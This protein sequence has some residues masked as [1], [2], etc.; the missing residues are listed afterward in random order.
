MTKWILPRIVHTIHEEQLAEHGGASGVRDE[1]LLDSAL[2]RPKN[3]AAYG[4]PP[5]N[6]FELAASYAY[7]IIGN[8]PFLDG[9]KRTGFLLAYV[10]LRLNGWELKAAE[11]DAVLAVLS[12]AKGEWTEKEFSCWLEKCSEKIA[13]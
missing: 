7:G 2:T 10:F 5:P 4:N 1:G 8:H 9:N 3:L 6:I 13:D 11:A 12:L